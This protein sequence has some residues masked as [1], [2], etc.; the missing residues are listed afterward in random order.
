MK[1]QLSEL[2][3]NINPLNLVKDDIEISRLCTNSKQVMPG[4]LFIAIPGHKF[5]GHQFVQEAISKGAVA[6]LINGRDVGSVSIP[7]VSVASPRRALSKLSSEFYGNPSEKIMITGITGTNGKT[8]TAYLLNSILLANGENS[9]V[10]G[11]LGLK[12]NKRE[13]TKSLT[14]LDP[15]NLHSTISELV[16]ENVSHLIMEV[17]SHSIDQFRVADVKFNYAMFTNLSHDHLD[18]HK[19]MEEYFQAKSKLFKT[20]PLYATAIINT[21]CEY[22]KSLKQIC[23]APVVSTSSNSKDSIQFI[24]IQSTIYGIKGKIIAGKT[25]YDIHSPL[26]GSFNQENILLAVAAAHS[27]DI[28]KASIEKGINNC[29][30]IPGRMEKFNS[31]NGGTVIIDYAHTP[32]A[33]EKVL[34]DIKSLIRGN[35][36]TVF[37]AGGNRD[38]SKRALMA[39]I[40]ETYSH[41]CYITPDNPREEDPEFISRDII[42]GFTK[43]CFTNFTDR[44]QGILYALEHMSSEDAVVII[45]KGREE[46]QE[47]NGEKIYHSD[48]K[49][50]EKF[51]T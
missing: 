20:L 26:I 33:L 9:A 1:K 31:I 21:N 39:K 24:D 47:I 13:E 23:Q 36:L 8:T 34:Y 43:N 16:N 11:T 5:D 27:M 51:I 40:A 17:S 12:T 29:T 41:H 38:Q 45:G 3:K 15:V 49:V 14:T 46:Y 6:L 18:Y 48:F 19:T 2:V 32:D 28:P 4:D 50:V 44:K 37:G 22:G 25:R 7:I 42:S 10:L 35:I 30:H